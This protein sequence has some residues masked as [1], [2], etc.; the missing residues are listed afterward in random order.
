MSIRS[1]ILCLVV[2]IIVFLTACTCLV[3]WIQFNR[4]IH[5]TFREDSAVSLDL[6]DINLELFFETAK[7]EVLFA[8]RQNDLIGSKGQVMHYYD[9]KEVTERNMAVAPEAER[10]AW[11]V[12]ETLRAASDRYDVTFFSQTDGSHLRSPARIGG[13]YDPRT[14]AWFKNTMAMTGNAPYITDPYENTTGLPVCSAVSRVFDR[15]NKLF[16]AL[17]A[18][19]NL[20]RLTELVADMSSRTKGFFMLIDSKGLIL[21]DPDDEK[22]LMKKVGEV[23]NPLLE[24]IMR[25]NR[26]VLV[27]EYN[28]KT[29]YTAFKTGYAGYKYLYV[30]EEGALFGKAVHSQLLIILTAAVLAAVAIAVTFLFSKKITEPI[31]ML[32][33]ASSRVASGGS[34][35]LPTGK[36][37]TAETRELRDN[38]DVMLASLQRS[39]AESHAKSEEAAREADSAKQAMEEARKAKNE[40]E[41]KEKV[42]FEAVDHLTALVRNLM[43]STQK[44]KAQVAASSTGAD[45]QLHRVQEAAGQVE[46]IRRLAL[47]V[48]AKADA[49]VAQSAQ[50]REKA[51]NSDKIVR[52]VIGDI[53]FASEKASSLKQGMDALEKQAMGIG[54]IMNVISDVA[55]QTNLLALN[56]AIEAARAGE[57][58]R[59]FAVVADEVRKLAERTMNA[60]QEVNTAIT[61]IQENTS[62]NALA[63]DSTVGQIAAVVERAGQAGAALHEVVANIVTA[64]DEVKTIAAVSIEQTGGTHQIGAHMDIMRGISGETAEAMRQSSSA[65]A[66]LASQTANLE[67]L[68]GRLKNTGRP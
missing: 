12:L 66:E 5:D 23:N 59:G 27:G 7:Q 49:A 48:S 21:A 60:T 18:D 24:Q 40:A 67:D 17:G 62:R 10:Q 3:V 58:G 56:A 16:G 61:G 65:V 33:S 22:N 39:I 31:R 20:S 26:D 38:L 6:L 54:Q 46:G 50:A 1:K 51:V 35:E 25:Q 15:E 47:D 19:I 2:S 32:A 9:K 52:D 14:R 13:G 68:I 57:A 34:R 43:E 45:E 36:M 11:M 28:G 55:D 53:T 64:A 42:I 37:F 41:T 44:I 4:E 63:V 8:A 30:V 29:W